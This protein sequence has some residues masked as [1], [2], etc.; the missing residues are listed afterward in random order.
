LLIT[1][2]VPEILRTLIS[3]VMQKLCNNYLCS[4]IIN[5]EIN[6]MTVAT[7]DK[8]NYEHFTKNE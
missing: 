7:F 2:Y 1:Y 6:V 5:N 8:H 3:I 4:E